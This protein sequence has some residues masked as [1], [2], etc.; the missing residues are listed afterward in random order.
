MPACAG[1]QQV[2]MVGARRF[3]DRHVRQ[4]C[5]TGARGSRGG[6]IVLLSTSAEAPVRGRA[7]V[8][9]KGEQ[10]V[11]H[12]AV[13]RKAGPRGRGGRGRF[14]ERHFGHS[15]L[16]AFIEPTVLAV[17]EMFSGG[18]IQLGRVLTPFPAA[19]AFQFHHVAVIPA[20]S[21]VRA[22]ALL[23]VHFTVVPPAVRAGVAFD[24]SVAVG[25]MT[26][27]WDVASGVLRGRA[28][29][30]GGHV[31]RSFLLVAFAGAWARRRGRG[32]RAKSET[33]QARSK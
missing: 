10:G 21:R 3:Q 28:D 31:A 8:A 15:F 27:A 16:V 33:E 24:A 20:G 5:R 29:G 11:A 13:A 25:D 22:L 19:Q 6:V 1:C 30:A 14:D 23:T 4:T 2:P 7:N 26:G 9:V 12:F 18:G 32:R 17:D